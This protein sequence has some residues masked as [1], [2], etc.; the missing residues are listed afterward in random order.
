ANRVLAVIAS[1]YAF[2]GRSGVVHEGVN[3]ARRIEQFKEHPDLWRVAA[4][5]LGHPPR[6]R[7]RNDRGGALYEGTLARDLLRRATPPVGTRPAWQ[8]PATDAP[9]RRTAVC[10]HR[11]SCWQ[12]VGILPPSPGILQSHRGTDSRARDCLA[13]RLMNS[14]GQRTH[15]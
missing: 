14:R 10:L 15:P 11:S 5:R 4:P 7:F 8:A 12:G 3:P 2:A 6:S 13:P 1:M 9:T